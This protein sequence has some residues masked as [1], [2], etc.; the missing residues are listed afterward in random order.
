MAA[1][2]NATCTQCKCTIHHSSWS[3]HNDEKEE[4][5]FKPKKY[6][7]VTNKTVF[8]TQLLNQLTYQM[9]LS[10]ATFESQTDIYNTIHGEQDALRLSS[11]A[12]SFS[13]IENPASFPW[14]LNE[15]RYEDGWFL[16]QLIVYY[17]A[18]NCLS[19]TDLRSQL[20]EGNRRDLEQLC[21]CANLHT[22][23][24]S[25]KWVHHICSMKGCKEGFA[26]VDGNEKINRSVCAAPR[27]RVKIPTEHIFMT[28]MCT[29][30]PINGGRHRKPSKFCQ[31]HVFLEDE[32][33]DDTIES[34]PSQT[35]PTPHTPSHLMSRHQVGN[36]PE[37]DDPALLVGCRKERGVNRFH[38]RTAGILS[39]VRP[40]GIIVNSC[41]M[42]T[43]ESPTQVYLFLINTF[44]RGSDIE[45]LH[46]LGY[47]RA[48]DLHPFLCN[49]E[50]KGAYFAKWL[51]RKVNFLVDSFH[52]AHHTEKCCM[53][54]DNPDCKYH[55]Q[56]P[57]FNEIHG[58]NTECAE[59]SFRWLNRLKMSMK[60]MQQHKFN[61]FLKVM[62]NTRN[63]HLERTLREKKLM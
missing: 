40:C 63:L 57:C 29:R 32:E 11:F 21:E 25:P 14:K 46:Y 1:S 13:R 48:C 2:Y 59:Q 38:D 30:S 9:A 22:S 3:P 6:V 20:T 44:A 17:D 62:S 51:L 61:F 49:L 19:T 27:R 52:V 55:P 18:A 12:S 16:Y 35:L 45:R 34:D 50:R 15:K 26:V 41:E 43:C 23:Q 37:N 56:L 36:L 42:Y 33:E 7:Q 5:F 60:Q 47:D 53:P 39:L 54:P 28:S 10:G 8:E 31:Q 58:T 4:F 24:S